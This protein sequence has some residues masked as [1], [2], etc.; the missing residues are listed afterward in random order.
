M[1]PGLDLKLAIKTSSLS[2]HFHGYHIRA[3]ISEQNKIFLSSNLLNALEGHLEQT[4]E[5]TWCF[6]FLLL[7]TLAQEYWHWLRTMQSM[8]SH[9]VWNVQTYPQKSKVESIASFRYPLNLSINSAT[10]EHLPQ[11]KVIST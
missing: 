4:T 10:K 2:P 1:G 6:I 11:Y 8:N 7:A 3:D 5:K 9:V